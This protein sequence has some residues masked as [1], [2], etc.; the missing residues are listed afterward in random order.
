MVCSF[1]V[2]TV[3]EEN[4]KV[5]ISFKVGDSVLKINGQDVEVVTP[6]IAGEGTTLVPLR[7][8][9]EAFG[10]EVVWIAETRSIRLKYREVEV[11]LQIDNNIANVNDHTETLA[12]APMLVENTTMVPL[13]FISETFGA[14]VGYDEES[15]AISVVKENIE[16]GETIQG[17]IT[18]LY[19]GDSYY[20]W[21]MSTPK[22]YNMA[23]RTYDGSNTVF[24]DRTGKE[25]IYVNVIP[26]INNYTL[27]RLQMNADE[28]F[29][30]G[31]LTLANFAVN[32]DG[33]RYTYSY[34]TVKGQYKYIVQYV[35]DG[36]IYRVFM[37]CDN[38]SA[39]KEYIKSVV[40]SFSLKYNAGSGIYD[41]SNVNEDGTRTFTSELY[42]VSFNVPSYF[43]MLHG[44]K[45]NEIYLA[46]G[47]MKDLSFVQL[48]IYSKEGLSAAD[49][50]AKQKEDDISLLNE[51]IIK[52][53]SISKYTVGTA[54]AVGYDIT[55]KK[56]TNFNGV[57]SKRFFEV[58]DYVYCLG[59]KQ[60]SNNKNNLSDMILSSCKFD[61]I[62]GE[63]A[64]I[65]IKEEND[66]SQMNNYF[67]KGFTLSAPSNWSEI[68]DDDNSTIT[69]K[70]ERT[71]AEA[72]FLYQFMG[73]T[74]SKY[75]VDVYGSIKNYINQKA[76]ELNA[77][78]VSDLTSRAYQGK[79]IYTTTLMVKNDG[80][81]TYI[82]YGM[83]Y[84]G[85]YLYRGMLLQS[86]MYA[87]GDVYK[88][89]ED[90]LF[91]MK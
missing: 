8:I 84:Y 31:V 3:A 58:G 38:N 6:F 62:K 24:I 42:R 86:E 82:T 46:S 33:V 50:A 85:T 48:N 53:S 80:V 9:T 41:L 76:I 22:N 7:V 1:V 37:L 14:T 44:G 57:W 4:E 65:L 17:G 5:E 83:V 10:A 32:S 72:V 43:L 81:P 90:I 2:F 55:I 74:D 13:R 63:D 91:T 40:D 30:D 75:V 59:I 66:Y 68:K 64:G 19:V 29:E 23:E 52:V 20:G 89:F 69:L 28:L 36:I 39:N 88:E 67:G 56:S 12:V 87:F 34:G 15:K 35:K 51:N 16:I 78:T 21:M 71:G 73:A 54:A 79:T 25:M 18:E 60:H 77:E 11:L 26:N 45:D 27:E 70:E 47:D 61:E 49:Y